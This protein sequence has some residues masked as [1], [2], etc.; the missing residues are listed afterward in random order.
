M[1]NLHAGHIA[2]AEIARRHG[3]PVVASIFVNP[4][5]FGAGEDFSRYPAHAPGRLRTTGSRRHADIV[6]APDTH[7]MYAEPQ[8]SPCSR[9]SPT[10]CA[11]RIGPAIS[12]AWP[13]WS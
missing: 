6:F 7:E 8:P 5:Q 2:L 10:N 11:A 3:R 12:R 4:L 9:P 13:R 1:G